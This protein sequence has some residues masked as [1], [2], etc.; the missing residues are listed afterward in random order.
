MNKRHVFSLRESVFLCTHLC[1]HAHGNRADLG[2]LVVNPM[3]RYVF[4]PIPFE[5]LY[6][7]AQQTEMGD[8]Q[9]LSIAAHAKCTV[10]GYRRGTKREEK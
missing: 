7:E 2:L 9:S 6:D 1:V 5:G 8:H 3:Q 10:R 4:S